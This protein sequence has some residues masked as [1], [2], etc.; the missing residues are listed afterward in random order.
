MFVSF[1]TT[2]VF[3]S[4]MSFTEIQACFGSDATVGGLK[5]QFA[6]RIRTDVNLINEARENG[7]DCKD[8]Q[9]GGYSKG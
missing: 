7:V 8:I 2:R 5:F 9:L 3:H 1:G 6:T 4:L